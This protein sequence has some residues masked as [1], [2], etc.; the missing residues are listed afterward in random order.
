MRDLE[1]QARKLYCHLKPVIPRWLQIKLRQKLISKKRLLYADVWPIDEKVKYSPHGWSGWPEGKQFAL[2]ITHDVETAKGLEKC[3]ELTALDRNYNFR[4]SINFVAKEYNVS[5][6]LLEYLNN[7]G[8]EVGVHGLNHDGNLFRSRR[9]FDKQATEINYYLKKWEA[10][11]FRCPSMYHNLEWISDL[12]IEYDSST[13]D[14]DPFEPQPDGVGTIF[15]FWVEYDSGR[16]GYV[17]LPYTLAQ[18]HSLFIIMREKGIGIWK[19]KLDWVAEA[20]GMAL[21]ITHPDYMNFGG[22]KMKAEEYPV[23]FYTEFLEYIKYQYGGKYWNV[24]PK[25]MAR[26]WASNYAMKNGGNE[27]LKHY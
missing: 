25:D 8:F 23:Q 21:L 4:A 26:F 2:V 15:P 18:D 10:V 27:E 7:N 11:G 1:K 14:T 6:K 16:R 24:L 5:E 3:I 19:K 13:F 9:V 12:N 17:E 22:R 20:G